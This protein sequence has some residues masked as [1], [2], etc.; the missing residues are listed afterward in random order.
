MTPVAISRE[1]PRTVTV[2]GLPESFFSEYV[3]RIQAVTAADVERAAKQYL[4]TDKFAVIVV[5]DLARI[6]KPIREANLGSV[7]VVTLDEI[8]K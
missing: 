3:P 8:L 1:A 6:E 7:K 4:Q 2:Y 5:G